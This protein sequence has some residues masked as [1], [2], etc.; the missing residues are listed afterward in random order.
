MTL[1]GVD[2]LVNPVH[3]SGLFTIGIRVAAM[4]VLGL[5]VIG[6]GI[7]SGLLN[8]FQACGRW[9]NPCSAGKIEGASFSVLLL[10]LFL[11]C[12]HAHGVW[13]K[14]DLNNPAETG[15]SQESAVEPASVCF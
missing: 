4:S 6:M 1:S 3:N 13:Y 8:N 14:P 9:S 7:P 5:V 15:E 10:K 2:L 11:N 12:A